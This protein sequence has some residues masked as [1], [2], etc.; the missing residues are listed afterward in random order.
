MLG[1][2]RAVFQFAVRKDVLRVNPAQD[3]EAQGKLRGPRRP[4]S[5]R[6][7]GSAPNH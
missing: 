7:R 6:A 4:D 1:T 3:V 5:R 2:L